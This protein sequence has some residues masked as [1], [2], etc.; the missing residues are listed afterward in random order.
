MM[1]PFEPQECSGVVTSSVGV[2]PKSTPGKFRVIVDL[3]RPEGAS[4]NDQLLRELTHVAYSSIEDASLAM[5][6][7]GQGAQLA[8]I[9]I[10]DAYRIIPV[11]PED[12]PF[13]A[14][15]WQD[16][17]YIDCQLPFG[18]ASA[19]AIFSAVAEALEWILRRRGVRGVPHYL[20]DFLLMGAPGSHE[21][22]HVLAT[23]FSTCEEL[24]VPLAL[25]KVKGPAASLTFLG[26]RLCSTPLSVSLPGEKITALRGLLQELL[27]SK[28]V[29]D[30]Q[31]LESLVGYLVHATKVCPL[32]KP[33]SRCLGGPG[34]ASPNGLTL[35]PEPIWL[36]GIPSSSTGR[37]SPHTS[38]W[39]LGNPTVTCS[40]MRQGH[41]AAVLGCCLFG[42]KCPGLKT[43]A[44][45]QLL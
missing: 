25:D 2:V 11:H 23:T 44:C 3:S 41:G 13:L 8:K 30:V 27:S 20:D 39:C 31:T 33:F 9:D 16:R 24:G 37:V 6:A 17:V 4:V 34:Q 15:S 43:T 18:L 28:C 29:R 19:P 32:A 38:S 42:S 36:G 21:C 10:R 7:L 45:H 14:L 40:R 35:L 5:H 12:R 26:I 1:G 22:S